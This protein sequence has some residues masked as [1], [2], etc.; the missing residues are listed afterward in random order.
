MTIKKLFL[1][2]CDVLI[3]K[4]MTKYLLGMGM[5]IMNNVTYMISEHPEINIPI[6]VTKM[7]QTI[8]Y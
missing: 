2:Y 8:V 7:N 1:V 3:M 5:Y 6:S 4:T